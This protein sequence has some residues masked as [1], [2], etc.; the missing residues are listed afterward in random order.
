[1]SRLFVLWVVVV[2]AACRP[3]AEVPSFDSAAAVDAVQRLLTAE[4]PADRLSVVPEALAERLR[5]LPGPPDE[6]ARPDPA[7]LVLA[8][9]IRLPDRVVYRGTWR[10]RRGASSSEARAWFT[11]VQE[12]GRAR[13]LWRA[14]LIDA[15]WALVAR[16]SLD[17]GQ[18][19]LQELL[20]EDDHDPVLLDRAGWAAMR[21]GQV[22]QA[23][24]LFGREAALDATSATPLA[25]LAAVRVHQNRLEDA[26]ELLTRAAG[27]ERTAV[28]LANLGEVQR[29][30][31]R[32]DDAKA[33]LGEA[34]RLDK[35]NPGPLL[36]LAELHR[37]LGDVPACVEAAGRA[38]PLA[39]RLEAFA[40]ERL[41]AVRAAC[42]YLDAR[43]DEARTVYDQLV[44][45]APGSATTTRLTDFLR[46]QGAPFVPARGVPR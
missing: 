7:S 40:W 14:P 37:Q 6:A 23:E 33:T 20:D 1:M 46:L 13:V 43:D 5:A 26:L 19:R 16:G 39:D 10:E 30:L 27:L 36:Y 2:V 15:A 32:I 21:R 12:Q 42:L 31:G 18:A 29:R 41:A 3:A 34:W 38:W 4:T 28:T 9:K 44:R 17:E 25:S 45:R 35:D 24:A 22:E 8:E 11:L